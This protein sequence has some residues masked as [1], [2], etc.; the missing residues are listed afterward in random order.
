MT[1]YHKILAKA[2]QAWLSHEGLPAHLADEADTALEAVL[3]DQG[4]LQ[5][6]EGAHFDQGFLM[7]GAREHGL[8]HVFI[9]GGEIIQIDTEGNIERF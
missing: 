4:I 9:E 3:I 8:V 6:G 5:V 7:T 1:I 2:V